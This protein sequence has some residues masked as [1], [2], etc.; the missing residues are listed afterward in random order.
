MNKKELRALRRPFI[1][2]LFRKNKFNLTLT[3]IAALLA[4]AANLVISWLIKAISD[5]IS[6]VCL[7]LPFAIAMLRQI[8]RLKDG[9]MQDVPDGYFLEPLG[10]NLWIYSTLLKPEYMKQFYGGNDMGASTV[11][12]VQKGTETNI[13][14]SVTNWYQVGRC[15]C[16]DKEMPGARGHTGTYSLNLGVVT[17]SMTILIDAEPDDRLASDWNLTA[18]NSYSS[19]VLEWLK[20]C[21][22]DYGPDDLSQA[23]Y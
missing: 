3:V 21:Y 7:A 14:L 12:V 16:N 6:G 2:E 19:A 23:H 17:N 20:A 11:I 13:V 1:R 8:N 15:T 10:E 22:P 9:T 18:E 4:A 5:L